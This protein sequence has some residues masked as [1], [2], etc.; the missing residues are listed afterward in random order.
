MK[1]SVITFGCRVNQADSLQIEEQ[2]M[3]AG[4]RI[5]GRS[6]EDA[7]LVVVNTLLCHQWAFQSGGTPNRP[8]NYGRESDAQN[9]RHGLL[10]HAPTRRDH[11]RSLKGQSDRSQRSAR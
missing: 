3:F 9:H 11:R 5:G 8:E 2:L 7:D 4:E 1:Y 10:R 6:T